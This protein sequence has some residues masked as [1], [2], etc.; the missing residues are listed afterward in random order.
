[1]KIEQVC[2]LY[3]TADKNMNLDKIL[4]NKRALYAG[5][6]LVAFSLVWTSTLNPFANR[7]M[8]IDTSV[9]IAITQGLSRGFVLY[10]E[11]ADNKGPVLYFMS[12]PGFLVAGL[13]GVWVT[14]FVLMYISLFFMYKIALL[15]TGTKTSFLTVAFTSLAMH[16]FY[17]VHAGTEEYA[18]P[19]LAASLYIFTKHYFDGKKTSF[20]ELVILGASFAWATMIRLN[21]F[22]L[23]AGFC[24]VIVIESLAKKR[25][26]ETFK[27][28]GAFTLGTAAA[29]FPIFLYLQRHG[30][31]LDFYY[32]VIVSGAERGFSLSLQGFVNNFYL[33]INRNFSFIPLIVS[34]VWFFIK[35]KN[36]S[37]FY[38]AG[39]F[40]SYLLS[41]MFL[42]FTTGNS[43]WNLI[44]IPFFVP[45][46]AFF[47]DLFLNNVKMKYKHAALIILFCVAFSEGL[48]RLGF[49]VFFT[50]DSATPIR[51]AGRIIDENTRDG[52]TIITLGARADIYPFTQRVPASRFIFQSEAFDNIP[53]A[54]EEFVS[55]IL[56]DRPKIIA[57]LLDENGAAYMVNHWW[58]GEIFAMLE[59]DYRLLEDNGRVRIFIRIE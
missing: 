44:L 48:A 7:I 27:Y 37:G 58:H 28:I 51:A 13:T 4:S 41:V 30:I 9:Y 53:G 1:M 32:N 21:M 34:V 17:Y 3:L 8:N 10:S 35:Y 59:T 38:F 45:M 25:F 24:L 39:F 55:G 20:L 22:P 57:F 15:F 42:S 26:V 54:R 16:S 5:L 50:F 11:L 47:S 49:Y 19:F 36:L 31:F 6:A 43:H 14:Q 33:V 2:A 46:I 18:L 23:W 52:D 40:L 56:N 12:L 29:L